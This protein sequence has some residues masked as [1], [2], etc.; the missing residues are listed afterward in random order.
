M[1]KKLLTLGL[2]LGT[3]VGCAAQAHRTTEGEDYP[4]SPC[5]C[6]YRFINQANHSV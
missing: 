2:L 5:A 6:K 1:M 4:K 3:L